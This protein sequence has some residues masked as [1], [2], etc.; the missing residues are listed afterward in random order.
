VWNQIDSKETPLIL[1]KAT[2]YGE[3]A[4][5][6]EW[7]KMEGKGTTSKMVS[8]RR[9]N[10]KGKGQLSDLTKG[11]IYVWTNK[12]CADINLRTLLDLPFPQRS[13]IMDATYKV[14]RN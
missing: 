1:L 8:D 7:T 3:A 4:E 11:H 10:S 6:A 5:A 2:S 14:K 13:V 9:G 12:E